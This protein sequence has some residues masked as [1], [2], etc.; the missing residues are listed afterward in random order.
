M[1]RHITPKKASNNGQMYIMVFTF[2]KDIAN[3]QESRKITIEAFNIPSALEVF[4]ETVRKHYTNYFISSITIEP[5]VRE[6]NEGLPKEYLDIMKN[7]YEANAKPEIE[8]SKDNPNYLP[9]AMKQ[10]KEAELVKIA[11][12]K[13]ADI[14][15]CETDKTDEEITPVVS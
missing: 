9:E 2:H 1:N 10:V 3:R 5:K 15:K 13:Q 7:V 8:P 14:E 11:A 6:N 4:H 12:E